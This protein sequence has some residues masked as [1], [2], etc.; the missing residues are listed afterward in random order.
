MCW[1]P[2][3][4]QGRPEAGSPPAPTHPPQVRV[5]KQVALL[6]QS[7]PSSARL[8]STAPRRGR[9]DSSDAGSISG[10]STMGS[11][12]RSKNAEEALEARV[13]TL[14]SKVFWHLQQ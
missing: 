10:D 5:E 1:K 11:V 13:N 12:R 2:G 4:D 14:E 7:A 9:P 6:S 3:P 8:S